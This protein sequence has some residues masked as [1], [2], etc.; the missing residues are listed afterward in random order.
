MAQGLGPAGRPRLGRS[1]G[2]AAVCTGSGRGNTVMAFGGLHAGC[3]GRAA[4]PVNWLQI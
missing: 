4:R 3:A 1:S 2:L